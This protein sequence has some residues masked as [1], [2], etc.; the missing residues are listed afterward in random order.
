[1]AFLL[2]IHRLVAI[3]LAPIVY[4]RV[5]QSCGPKSDEEEGEKKEGH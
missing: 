4:Y 5:R 1:M 3:C 2:K